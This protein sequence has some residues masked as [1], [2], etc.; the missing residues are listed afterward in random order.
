MNLE[1]NKYFLAKKWGIKAL[2]TTGI[3]MFVNNIVHLFP[4]KFHCIFQ[5]AQLCLHY[6]GNQPVLN[7]CYNIR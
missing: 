7:S 2:T 4:C 1:L 6:V 5:S 3:A